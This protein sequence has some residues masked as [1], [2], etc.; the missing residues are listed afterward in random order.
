MNRF[1][2]CLAS[3]GLALL[4]GCATSGPQ[5]A[6]APAPVPTMSAA[7]PSTPAAPAAAL[8]QRVERIPEPSKVEELSPEAKQVTEEFI[9]SGQGKADYVVTDTTGF[10]ESLLSL[11]PGRPKPKWVAP[12]DYSGVPSRG[13]TADGYTIDLVERDWTGIILTPVLAQ[14]AK[15]YV[16]G[17]QL[18]NVEIHPLTDGRVRIWV[19]LRN[20]RSD[21]VPTE[22]ACSFRTQAQLEPVT[23]FYRL[24]IPSKG[25]RD[26]FFVSPGGSATSYTVLVRRAKHS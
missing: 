3:V 11:Q 6:K 10:P 9:Q 17:I 19:R 15:A 13:L 23:L 2:F 4:V 21:G 5:S 22:V 7:V 14:V 25:S 26:V 24:D 8:L 1:S 18:S 20:Q 16:S 12:V